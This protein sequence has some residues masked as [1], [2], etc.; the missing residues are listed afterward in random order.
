MPVNQKLLVG[1]SREHRRVICARV[2]AAYAR[3]VATC[4][5]YGTD[6]EDRPIVPADSWEH[7]SEEFVAVLRA[8]LIETPAPPDLAQ[9]RH[10]R[11]DYSDT[12]R[13]PLDVSLL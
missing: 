13:T 1:F 3:H 7:F 4:A 12:Y 6:D 11:R 5:S 9:I 2:D 8:E 10:G